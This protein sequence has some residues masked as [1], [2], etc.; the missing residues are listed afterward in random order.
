MRQR[1]LLFCA[2]LFLTL[3]CVVAQSTWQPD[4]AGIGFGQST[5]KQWVRMVSP[6]QFSVNAGKQA[7]QKIEL[8]FTIQNGLHINSHAPHSNFLIPTTLTLDQPAGVEV[9][10]VE[11]PTGVNYHF[12]FSPKDALS[13]YTGEF[14]VLIQ[15]HAKPGHYTLH[16]QL[17]YQACDNRSCNPPKTLPLT[18]NLTAR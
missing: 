10:K 11:Y 4:H 5:D 7:R 13:V 12:A 16:G 9:T 1:W 6:P 3:G 17:R 2:M 8:Q 18:L 15:V 14:G